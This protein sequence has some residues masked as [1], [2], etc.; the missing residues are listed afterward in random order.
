MF[1]LYILF[2]D[3]KASKYCFP[4]IYFLSAHKSFSL[5]MLTLKY[6]HRLF[7]KNVFGWLITLLLA[8]NA[9]F[10]QQC[11]PEALAA[12]Y[13]QYR[14]NFNKHFI[15]I[16][17]EPSGC[18]NDGIGQHE[19]DPCICDKEGYSLPATSINIEINGQVGLHDRID[20]TWKDHDCGKGAGG[21]IS[22]TTKHGP[23]ATHKHNWLDMGS[24]TPHQ[25]GWYMVTLATE[26][27]LLGKNSQPAEQQKVLEEIFLALQAYRRLDIRAQ[28]LAKKRYD[29]IAAGFEIGCGYEVITED[30]NGEHVVVEN[31]NCLCGKKY[32]GTKNEHSSF[33]VPCYSNCNFTP[34]TDGYSGFFLREDA[35]GA[36]EVL[37]DPD[38]G[39][40]NI[41]HVG[42]DY[43]NSLKP[44]CTTTFSQ[45]CYLAHR[46]DYMSQ[47][48]VYSLMIG[49]AFIKKY[50]PENATITTCSGSIHNVLEIAQNIAKALADRVD[51]EQ[52]GRIAWPGSGSCCTREVFLNISEGGVLWPFM[53]GLKKAA[54]YVDGTN[55]KSSIGEKIAWGTMVKTFDRLPEYLET[56]ILQE[57]LQKL[58]KE[59]AF[60]IELAA[61]GW[62]IDQ[63]PKVGSPIYFPNSF[64][65]I[66]LPGGIKNNIGMKD[67]FYELVISLNK[68]IFQPI[69]NLL[70]PYGPNLDK[71]PKSYFESLLCSAPCA[72]PCNKTPD[73]DQKRANDKFPEYWPEF[74]CSNTPNWLG[75]RW[76]GNGNEINWKVGNRQYNGLDFMS[77]YNI[78]LLNYNEPVQN[79]YNPKN[80]TPNSAFGHNRISGPGTLCPD[81]TALYTVLPLNC[82]ASANPSCLENLV[83]SGS[84]NLLIH[85]ENTNG[86][87][88]TASYAASTATFLQADFNETRNI[89]T[90]LEGMATGNSISDA[91][92]FTLRKPIVM[93]G[94]NFYVAVTYNFCDAFMIADVRGEDMP[95][96]SYNWSITHLQ[97]GN[98]TTYTSAGSQ[99]YIFLGNF[100]DQGD[101]RISVTISGACPGGDYTT[102]TIVH[103]QCGNRSQH[104][105][106][107]PNPAANSISIGVDSY[108]IGSGGLEVTISR[109]DGTSNSV[110]RR[111]YTNGE[112]V[113]ISSLSEGSYLLQTGSSDLAPTSTTL[114]I[115]RQ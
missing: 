57:G 6:Y 93:L 25:L 114:I 52:W 89:P 66:V 91:C 79:Y 71:I 90:Y 51:S 110:S 65:N 76:E 19:D 34:R 87:N 97:T 36:L 32:W 30:E 23:S 24:E 80:P 47:D 35:T 43:N 8:S 78:Y 113:N 94:P 46:Q 9:T 44:P 33:G 60:F 37:H 11:S 56:P 77:L 98:V 92:D 84:S 4:L 53:E 81:Q 2:P 107:Y 115:S 1:L 82:N 13:W 14:E 42:S 86:T 109:L 45:P 102:T 48:Q 105:V 85:N 100:P 75:Q 96:L 20:S 99:L 49:L 18:I 64:P 63:N 108:T 72:G 40:Y 41:D 16:D 12:K 55:H 38:E 21:D 28:C 50:V 83:W 54:G 69:N 111:I 103:F 26:Y 7:L 10:S 59:G 17:R 74:E 67:V 104:L 106:V 15:L 31:T 62:D 101:L 95:G 68:Q 61:L 112:S 39:K 22:W 70:Y 5:F 29:E 58:Y 27:A 73:Y 3:S 88:V